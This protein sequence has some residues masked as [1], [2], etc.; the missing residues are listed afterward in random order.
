MRITLSKLRPQLEASAKETAQT[1]NK[2][3]TEN[4]SVERARML[5]KR[6]ED[7]ANVQA[8]VAMNLK[9]ECEADLAEAMPALEDAIGTC[10]G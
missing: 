10:V 9:T 2:I 1:M 3:E 7:V 5:V 6:D 8:E 4:I